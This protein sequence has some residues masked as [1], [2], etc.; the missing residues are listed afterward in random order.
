MA[1]T[2]AFKRRVSVRA[3]LA[4]INRRLAHEDWDLQQIRTTRGG[5]RQRLALGDYYVINYSMN[6]IVRKLDD[7]DLEDYARE[8]GC[9]KPYEQLDARAA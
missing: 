3:L 2:H 5:I 1:V 4:R 6:I 9:L 8:L 7:G